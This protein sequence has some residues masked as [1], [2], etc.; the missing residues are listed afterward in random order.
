LAKLNSSLFI[1]SARLQDVANKGR[2][3]R[4]GDHSPAVALLQAGIA[5]LGYAMSK[6]KLPNGRM[7]GRY[8][9]E[10]MIGIQKVQEWAGLTVDGT[11]GAD[12]I[13]MIDKWLVAKFPPKKAAV[14]AA[15]AAPLPV[16]RDYT[17]GSGDPP[18]G[19][20]PGAGVWNS[21]PTTAGALLQWAAIERILGLAAA[22]PG[23]NAARHMRHYLYNSGSTYTIDLE[24]MIKS[25]PVAKQ[26]L[27]IEFRQAQEFIEKLPAGRHNFTSRFA[28]SAY[29]RKS[30]SADWYFA[31]GGYSYWGKGVAVVSVVGGVKHFDVDFQFKFYDRYNWDGG[32]QVTIAGVVITDDFMGEF[33]RQGLAREFDCVGEIGRRVRW[34][35]QSAAP[36]EAQITEK[37]GR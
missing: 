31:I 19:A 20:D 28:E 25:V 1:G 12:T 3:L 10:L 13:M 5:D 17:I 24:G 18:F 26:R 7:D 6:S 14:P 2:P 15:V 8:G 22:Y 16:T 37:V 9:E 35:G 36:T 23:P 4:L 29:N 32:K 30:E 11:T 33:H 27:I 34:S 21:K